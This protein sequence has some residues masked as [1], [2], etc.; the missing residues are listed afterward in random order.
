MSPIQQLVAACASLVVLTGVVGLRMLIVRVREMR[1]RRIHP[2]S[3]ALS[4][5]RAQRLEDSRAS[6]NY[7][8]LYELPVLFYALCLAAIATGHIPAW[9]PPLAW[10]FV[11]LRGVHSVIQC[12]Y[13]KVMH[14][15][16]VFL[17]GFLLVFAMWVAY[18][19]SYLSA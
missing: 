11:V 18:A 9:L 19:V 5:Q 7:N 13:N 2:Q 15:F 12:T 8:H 14:R 17:A 1:A 6:D 16:A 10:L 3:I 4:A